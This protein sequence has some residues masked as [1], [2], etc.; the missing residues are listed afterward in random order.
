MENYIISQCVEKKSV[1]RFFTHWIGKWFLFLEK[2]CAKYLF[3]T[4]CYKKNCILPTRLKKQIILIADT[5]LQMDQGSQ[6][7]SQ[8]HRHS[9]WSSRRESWL[10]LLALRLVNDET[11]SSRHKVR[12]ENRHEWHR[13]RSCYLFLRQV[14]RRLFL[15]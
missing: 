11:S 7:A 9:S 8:I 4:H 10:F 13:S 14:S 2:Q 3:F 12:K 6:D 1:K 15:Q 5:L